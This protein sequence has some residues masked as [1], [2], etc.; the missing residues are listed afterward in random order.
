MRQRHDQSLGLGGRELGAHPEP[1]RHPHLGGGHGQVHATT[2][3]EHGRWTHPLLGPSQ[4]HAA[5]VS[6]VRAG[7]LRSIAFDDSGEVLA[8]CGG[9]GSVR[10]W[11]APDGEFRSRF[12]NPSGWARSVTLDSKGTRVVVGAGTGEI[13]VRDLRADRFTAHLSGHTGRILMLGFASHEDQLVSAAA[14]GTVRLWSL[15]EQRQI[16]EVRVDASLHC[17]AYDGVKD[18]VLV[19]SAAGVVALK[20]RN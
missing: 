12:T 1:G 10:V 9:D 13:S 4:R 5:L 19:G 8:A 2:G 15:S 6:S 18:Q 14:D 3:R 20:I 7:R 17:A 11:Q 16:A